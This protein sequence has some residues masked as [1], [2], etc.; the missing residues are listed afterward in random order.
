MIDRPICDLDQA[1]GPVGAYRTLDGSQAIKPGSVAES[2]IWYRITTADDDVMP[3][4]DANKRPLTDGEK[5]IIEAT[6]LKKG[7]STLGSGHSFRHKC[8]LCPRFTASGGAISRLID[9]CSGHLRRKGS[10]RVPPQT[11]AP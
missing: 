8:P 6:G 9:W 7:L 2:A 1:D 11:A 4:P 3:P 5:E 10:R